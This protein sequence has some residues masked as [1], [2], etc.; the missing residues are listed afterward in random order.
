MVEEALKREG[1]EIVEISPPDMYE[2]LQ[3]ASILLNADGCK[4]F[5][6]FFRTGEWNDTGAEQMARLMRLPGPLRWVYYLWVKH[7]KKDEVWAGLVEN[8]RPL[9]AFEN[10][11]WVAKREAYRAKWFDWWNEA[12]LDVLIAPPNATPAVPH[13]GMRDAV[14][15]CNYTFLFNLVSGKSPGV[16]KPKL[17]AIAR[18]HG[19]C[20]PGYAC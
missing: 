20:P 1:H 10:W 13:D 5:R 3:I 14:S 19:R 7:V 12:D 4:M 18:L 9:S 16:E 17:T 6:S 11:Q 8:W 2:G 15:S